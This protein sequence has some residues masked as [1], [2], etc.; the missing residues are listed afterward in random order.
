MVDM[1]GE[2]WALHTE[3]MAVSPLTI[4]KRW[5]KFEIIQ[6]FNRSPNARRMEEAYL[7]TR[8]SNRPVSRVVTDIAALINGSLI[9]LKGRSFW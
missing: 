9:K 5:T 3:W 7:E 4:K 8:L 1:T 6:L 2:G